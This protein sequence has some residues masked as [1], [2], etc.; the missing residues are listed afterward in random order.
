MRNK[1]GN[2]AVVILVV[3]IVILSGLLVYNFIRTELIKDEFKEFM[4]FQ[5]E[6]TMFITDECDAEYDVMI[7]HFLQ[8]KTAEIMNNVTSEKIA[9]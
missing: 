6:L 3:V 8:E 4:K 1:K 9:E 5:M 2:S 7:D